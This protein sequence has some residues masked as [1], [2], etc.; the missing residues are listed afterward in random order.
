MV[1]T[2]IKASLMRLTCITSLTLEMT[3][4]LCFHGPSFLCQY[5]YKLLR[6]DLKIEHIPVIGP[7]FLVLSLVQCFIKKNNSLVEI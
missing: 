2:E 1:G 5:G 6:N 7:R 3:S 4:I